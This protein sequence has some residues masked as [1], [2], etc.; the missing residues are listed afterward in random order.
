MTLRPPTS[1]TR[2]RAR[3]VS[4]VLDVALFLLLVSASIGLLY[5]VE[6]PEEPT[7]DPD[8]AAEAQT[9]LATTTVTV[10]YGPPAAVGEPGRQP[11]RGTVAEHLAAAT[12]ANADADDRPLRRAPWYEGAV[13]NATRNALARI[14]DDAAVQVRT[15]WEPL[16]GSGVRGGLVV[17]P[18]PPP[19]A[20]V[21][22]AT[23]RVPVGSTRDTGV[24]APGWTE[25]AGGWPNDT[26]AGSEAGDGDDTGATADGAGEDADGPPDAA[27][28][29][30]DGESVAT[31]A[32]LTLAEAADRGGCEGVAS[33]VARRI[34]GEAFAPE[35]T[36]VALR[37]GGPLRERT[38]ER[39]RTLAEP[40]GLDGSAV[41][42]DDSARATNAVLVDALVA[43]LEP[44]ACD[45]ENA[46]AAAEAAD[47][48]AVTIVV[49]TWSR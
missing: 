31:P 43:E 38:V 23:V 33:A 2:P 11:V 9:T 15:R 22:A 30:F 3:G 29:S 45:Y 42:V 12:L 48:S 44:T 39:Y 17:G 49:R 14:E 13:R 5:A 35:R 21:H 6:A 26:V 10:R 25:A 4:T 24:G 18:S 28:H 1:A 7:A 41:P 27:N 19:D 47:P 40:T 36:Q 34:V 46:T 32:T 16:P 20:D 37:S 8:V